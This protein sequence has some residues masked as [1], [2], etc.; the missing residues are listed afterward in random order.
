MKR[1][2]RLPVQLGITAVLAAALSFVT[3]VL[4]DRHD[5]AQA[6]VNYSKNASPENDAI[7]RAER[8]KN[9]RIAL[10]DHILS[11][12]ALFA[13]MNMGWFLVRRWSAKSSE[14]D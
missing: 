14:T 1:I 12:G 3:P 4:V 7:L 9:Q 8:A 13:L 5:Y 11:A 2:A 6:V 10:E